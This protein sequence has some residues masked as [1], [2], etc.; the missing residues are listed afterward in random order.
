MNEAQSYDPDTFHPSIMRS[1]YVTLD[2]SRLRLAEPHANIPRWATFNEPLHKAVFLHSRTYQLTNTRKR[3]WNKKYPICITL[4]EGELGVDSLLEEQEEG[5]T[6]ERSTIPS[7]QSSVTLYLFG[8]TGREKEEWFQHLLSASKAAVQS[9][10]NTE[11][12]AGNKNVF[13]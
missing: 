6:V 10:S 12:N 2:S 9:E 3:I 11:E 5:E 4:A 8:R 13:S 7:H 1:V